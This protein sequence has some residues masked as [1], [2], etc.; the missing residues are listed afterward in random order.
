MQ[1]YNDCDVMYLY[2]FYAVFYFVPYVRKVKKNAETSTGLCGN[3]IEDAEM[4]F[5]ESELPGSD[6]GV[7]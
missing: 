3:I 1:T 6:R 2:G 5:S 4:S 7:F